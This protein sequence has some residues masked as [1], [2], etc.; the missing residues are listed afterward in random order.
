MSSKVPLIHWLLIQLIALSSQR[1]LDVTGII[2]EDVRKPRNLLNKRCLQE[3]IQL[4]CCA[5]LCNTTYDWFVNRVLFFPILQGKDSSPIRMAIVSVTLW[6]IY[7][8]FS[9]KLEASQM[10]SRVQRG[11]LFEKCDGKKLRLKDICSVF[12][13]RFFQPGQDNKMGCD[14]FCPIFLSMELHKCVHN[15]FLLVKIVDKTTQIQYWHLHQVFWFSLSIW[16]SYLWLTVRKHLWQKQPPRTYLTFCL[17]WSV[18]NA[19]NT[20][21]CRKPE[22]WKISMKKSFLVTLLVFIYVSIV[23]RWVNLFPASFGW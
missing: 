18:G 4:F 7:E 8:E 21:L 22:F 20:F 23:K 10:F 14:D 15:W 6:N 9:G 12:L 2:I 16:F 13:R 11:C 19:L 17:S 1:N 3:H 5:A